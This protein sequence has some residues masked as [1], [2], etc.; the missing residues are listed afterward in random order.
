M[1]KK[2]LFNHK[3]C[4]DVNVCVEGN[5]HTFSIS[6]AYFL[7]VSYIFRML[8]EKAIKHFRVIMVSETHIGFL[9][10]TKFA[11]Y[12]LLSLN[13]SEWIREED[14]NLSRL[15]RNNSLNF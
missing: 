15:E 12:I 6:I 8:T 1:S 14:F 7:S 5:P 11:L 13:Q 9:C 4:P 2:G 3:L 10:M